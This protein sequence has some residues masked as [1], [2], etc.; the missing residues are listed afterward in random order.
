[1]HGCCLRKQVFIIRVGSKNS[2]IHS[3]PS[4]CS[5][6]DLSR[7]KCLRFRPFSHSAPIVASTITGAAADLS[8]RAWI[9]TVCPSDEFA[10]LWADESLSVRRGPFTAEGFIK[11]MNLRRAVYVHSDGFKQHMHFYLLVSDADRCGFFIHGT[12]AL[13]DARPTLR[14]IDLMLRRIACNSKQP[15]EWGS[16][17]ARLPKG[18]ITATGGIRSDWDVEGERLVREVADCLNNPV[19]S[20]YVQT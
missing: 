14:A 18:P 4:V 6:P 12:H 10:G 1:M 13:M 15:L 3:L 8:D 2:R 7:L 5:Y 17:W 9:Y 20:A 16:E 11:E 19:V